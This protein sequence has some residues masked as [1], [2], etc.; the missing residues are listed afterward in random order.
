MTFVLRH[1][2][3]LLAMFVS[4]GAFAEPLL[5]IEK[6]FVMSDGTSYL[7]RLK[8]ELPA[9]LSDKSFQKYGHW[10][11]TGRNPSYCVSSFTV[12]RRNIAVHVNEK[13]F[14]DLCNVSSLELSERNG[15]FIVSLE[16]G[17]AGDS[18]SAQYQFQ[19][20]YLL[21]RMVRHGEFPDVYERTLYSHNTHDD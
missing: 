11:A 14:L 21:E 13:A 1:L 17:D 5:P 12:T 2:L 8:Q 9:R 6:S 7:V 15:R 3:L 10:G 19:G 18:F 4:S 16:G 20:A